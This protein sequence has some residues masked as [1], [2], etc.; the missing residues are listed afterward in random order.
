MTLA[1]VTPSYAPDFLRFRRLHESVVQHAPPD[2]MHHVLVPPPDVGRFSSIDSPRLRVLRQP[3]VLPKQFVTTTRLSRIP[4]LPRGYRVGALNLR[5]PWP[6]IRGWVL[7]QMVKLAFVSTLDADVALLIDSAVLLVREFS[8]ETFRREGSVRHYRV[9]HAVHSGWRQT[10]ARLLDL[11]KPG[12]DHADYNA[13]VVSWSPAIVR[14]LL[15]RIEAVSSL[16]WATVI[17]SQLDVSECFLYDEYL[18][19]MGTPAQK[20]FTSDQNFCHSYWGTLTLASADEFLESMPA[21]DI[22]I[23]VQSN[24][25]TSESELDYIAAKVRES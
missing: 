18:A 9:P 25:D 23:W 10:A 2:V 5:R 6:P 22:A 12:D 19:A 3:E 7:Q 16:P 1:I 21:T 4:H 11:G 13:G 15:A 14:E 24:S 17:G 8:E 20:A